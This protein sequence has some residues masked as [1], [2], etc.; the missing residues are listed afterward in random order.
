[1]PHGS[2]YAGDADKSRSCSREG[3]SVTL[4][5]KYGKFGLAFTARSSRDISPITAD[6]TRNSVSFSFFYFSTFKSF[7]NSSITVCKG[8]ILLT[9]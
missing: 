6:R 9:N 4:N 1:M 5:P 7:R 2:V 3:N 8:T